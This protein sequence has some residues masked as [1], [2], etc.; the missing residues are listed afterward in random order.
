M[1]LFGGL[2]YTTGSPGQQTLYGA[3]DTWVWDGTGW[4]ER[5]PNFVPPGMAG[6]SMVTNVGGNGVVMLPPGLQVCQFANTPC[7]AP[8]WIWNGLDWVQLTLPTDLAG[9]GGSV[10]A[11]D[12]GHDQ[13]VL[14]GGSR[15]YSFSGPCTN[16]S[17]CPSNETW[18]W[19]GTTWTKS[20]PANRPP[21]SLGANGFA[22]DSARGQL[23]MFGRYATGGPT[24]ETWI[25]DGNNWTQK[26]PLSSPS[27]RGG[28][29]L[30]VSD[31]VKSQ[32]VLFGG[33]MLDQFQQRLNDLWAWDGNNWHLVAASGAVGSPSGG[34]LNSMVYDAA[35]GQV[36]LQN[37]ICCFGPFTELWGGLWAWK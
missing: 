13:I 30:L 25:W 24:T 18:I 34:P 11:Y 23:V 9:F 14:F 7:T 20:N 33:S 27:V 21:P 2:A 6:H 22:Y 4:V 32:V 28:L 3:R 17:G 36:L 37:M 31:S 5:T 15:T 16:V 8:F 35:R 26:F 29:G 10:A 19:N 12:E 1:V